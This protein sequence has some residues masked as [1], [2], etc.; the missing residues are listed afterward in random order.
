MFPEVQRSD[1]DTPHINIT[2]KQR[3]VCF[4]PFVFNFRRPWVITSL[5]KAKDLYTG[6][7]W[8][9]AGLLSTYCPVTHETAQRG[10]LALKGR[11]VQHIAHKPHPQRFSTRVSVLRTLQLRLELGRTFS[12]HTWGEQPWLAVVATWIRAAEVHPVTNSWDSYFRNRCWGMQNP[13][14]KS[15]LQPFSYQP[16][17]SAC[18][19]AHRS[20]R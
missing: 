20:R 14:H 11:R 2:H 10:F 4:F 18:S 8:V 19:T 7:T 17:L 1:T 9:A 15:S 5:Q 13:P 12:L 3:G 6:T 16:A